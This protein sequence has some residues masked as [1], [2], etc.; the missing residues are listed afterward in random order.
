[1]TTDQEPRLQPRTDVAAMAPYVPGRSAAEVKRLLGLDDVTK[2]ASNE[3][4]FGPS[5][6]AVAAATEGRHG[7]NPYPDGAAVLLRERLA[8]LHGL[9]REHIAVGNGSDEIIL[10]LALAYL[11]PGNEAVLA[12]PPYSIHRN[13]VRIAGGVPVTVPLRE[14]MHDLDAMGAAIGEHTRLVFVTNPHNPTGTAV[15]ADDL[16]RFIAT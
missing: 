5:P 14:Y 4:P 6:R 9:S 2:L 16:R 3:N 8:A 10:L 1:M 12:D 13:G 15:P 11:A 7:A